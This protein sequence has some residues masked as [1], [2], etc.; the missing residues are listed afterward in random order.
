[1]GIKIFIFVCFLTLLVGLV[2]LSTGIYLV[3]K[4]IKQE[5]S[6]SDKSEA[7][8]RIAREL[9]MFDPLSSGITFCL[10]TGGFIFILGLMA[11]ALGFGYVE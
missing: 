4:E 6:F 1:M 5:K 7:F 8:N 3:F 11:L 2:L 9:L 10:L